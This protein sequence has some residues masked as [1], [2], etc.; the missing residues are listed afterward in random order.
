MLNLTNH[1]SNELSKKFQ[2]FWKSARK[3]TGSSKSNLH[4]GLYMANSCSHK[5]SLLHAA[6]LSCQ[7]WS[8]S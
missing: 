3:M 5:L 6:K 2:Q 1:S 7:I 8:D 4:F